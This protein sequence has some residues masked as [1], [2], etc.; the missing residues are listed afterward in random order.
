VG[1]GVGFGVGVGDGTG[2][3]VGVGFGVGVGV[4]VG[5]GV[6]VGDGLGVLVEPPLTVTGALATR[7]FDERTKATVWVP[8][9][10]DDGTNIV[11]RNV[12]SRPTLTF[13][14]PLREPSQVRN[15]DVPAE[16]LEPVTKTFSPRDAADGV[17][18]I[19]GALAEA[20]T[21]AMSNEIRRNIVRL[22]PHFPPA[23]ATRLD[24]RRAWIRCWA[25]V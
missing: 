9:L 17:T 21:T 16:T 18:V 24:V 7:A 20:G 23:N 22:M 12:P 14:I 15:P 4:G 25:H 1:V 3:G 5:F 19:D 2:V 8:S 10:A 11:V 13:G 6:G